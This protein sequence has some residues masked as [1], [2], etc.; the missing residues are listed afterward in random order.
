MSVADV[1]IRKSGFSQCHDVIVIVY[2]IKHVVQFIAHRPN[3]HHPG[4]DLGIHGWFV[5]GHIRTTNW[6]N[7]NRMFATKSPN[8]R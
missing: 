7:M 5:S 6:C 3:A 2:V 8:S 1:L 4:L